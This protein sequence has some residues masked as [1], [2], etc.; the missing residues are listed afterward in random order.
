MNA[1]SPVAVE[2]LGMPKARAWLT[3]AHCSVHIATAAL[4]IGFARRAACVSRT[5]SVTKGVV[6][7]D[8]AFGKL[9]REI[10][11]QLV[12]A[13]DCFLRAAAPLAPHIAVLRHFGIQGRFFRRN[14]AIISPADDN[15]PQGVPFVPAF[16]FGF[17]R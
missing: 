13:V 8:A 16:D 4:E 2:L 17:F 5:A 15:M 12:R 3:L 9:G 14:V 10:V 6:D 11:Q 1:S 7:P